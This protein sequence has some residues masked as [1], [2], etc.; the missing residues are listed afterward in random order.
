MGEWGRGANFGF[1][2][3]ISKLCLHCSPMS[4][5]KCYESS[6]N[7]ALQAGVVILIIL[8]LAESCGSSAV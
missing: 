1:G 5:G 6:S 2:P 8:G 4:L 3:D 7:Y